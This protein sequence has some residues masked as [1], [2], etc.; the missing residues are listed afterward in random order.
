MLEARYG[1]NRDGF[2]KA[3]VLLEQAT[4]CLV[5]WK[6]TRGWVAR[7]STR[8]LDSLMVALIGAYVF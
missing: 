6:T 3:G 2:S 7:L 8:F 4:P 1:R 5:A